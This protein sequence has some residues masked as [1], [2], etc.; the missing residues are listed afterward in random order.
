MLWSYKYLPS[1]KKT[2]VVGRTTWIR[3]ASD[4]LALIN[5]SILVAQEMTNKFAEMSNKALIIAGKI[6]NLK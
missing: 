3:R 5:G 4:T 1:K 6:A 2:F